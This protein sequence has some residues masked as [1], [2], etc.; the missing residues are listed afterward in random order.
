MSPGRIRLARRLAAKDLLIERRS[1]V[2]VNQVLPFSGLVM[3]VFA[4]AL[5][6]GGVLERAAPGLVWLAVLFSSLS[7]VQRSFG[8]ETADGAMESLRVA[9]VDPIAL[10][11]GK[12]AALAIELLVLVTVLLGLA[13]VLYGTEPRAEGIVLLV[14]TAI[15]AT[16]GLA[17]LGTIYGGLAAGGS[18]R[19]TLLP[20]LVLPVAAPV[21]IGAT[22]GV[23]AALGTDRTAVSEGWPWVGLLLVFAVAIG[24]GG[25][26]AFGT[27]IE[28]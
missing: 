5:G 1:R 8:L 15:S 27:L 21:L 17:A 4:F 20:L 13:V 3:V 22:R 28:D 12:A 26:L 9:G 2:L 6:T 23:E 24:V 14:T 11:L 16:L 25:A 18:G 7:T 19:E 10:F